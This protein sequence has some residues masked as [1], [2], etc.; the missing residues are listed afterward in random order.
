VSQLTGPYQI[1]DLAPERRAWLS[2]L[3]LPRPKHCMVGLL[4]VDVTAARQLI[5]EHKARS[6]ETLSFTGYLAFCLAR[7]VDEDRTVQAYR[8]GRKQLVMFD[9]VDVGLMVERKTGKERAPA[10][11]VIRGA[12]HKAYREIHEEIRTVQSTPLPPGGGMPPVPFSC[13]CRSR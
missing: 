6:G 1:V 13:C 7:A 11:T 8:K 5:A 9:D 4:E 10:G 2:M 12:N 3:D